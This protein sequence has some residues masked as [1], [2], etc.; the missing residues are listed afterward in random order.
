MISISERKKWLQWIVDLI[1]TDLQSLPKRQKEQLLFEASY[2]CGEHFDSPDNSIDFD[3]YEEFF[4]REKGQELD[5]NKL[6][7]AFREWL[8]KIENIVAK[9]RDLELPSKSF[10]RSF[11][12][13]YPLPG[14]RKRKSLEADFFNDSASSEPIDLGAYKET[15]K[16]DFEIINE[17]IDPHDYTNWAIIN[18]IKLIDGVGTDTVKR[19]KG[20]NRYFVNLKQMEKIYCTSSCASRSIVKEKRDELKEKHPE[21]Y[22]AYLDKQNEYSKEYYRRRQIEKHGPKVKIGKKRKRTVKNER[23]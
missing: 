3:V 15:W 21:K 11:K 8:N 2:F 4:P 23:P 18:F 6:Q 9:G 14:P 7:V 12:Y 22:K 5:L 16:R 17:P 20:C 1:Q 10:L 13:P 19:C